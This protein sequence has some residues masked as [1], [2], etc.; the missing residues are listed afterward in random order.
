MKE[1]S[2]TEP[3]HGRDEHQSLSSPHMTISIS[4]PMND[5]EGIRPH[6]PTKLL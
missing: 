2:T 6:N 4:H 5:F 1:R 3:P